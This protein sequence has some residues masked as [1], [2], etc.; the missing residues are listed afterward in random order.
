MIGGPLRLGFI[1]L[2]D[3][4]PLAVADASGLFEAE[5]L[6]VTLVREA[7]WAT[8]RDKVQARLLDGAHMLGPMPLASSLGAGGERSA[9]IAPMTLN[10]N[11][12]AISVSHALA[13]RMR[14][15]DPQAMAARPRTAQ[16]LRQVVEERRRMGAPPLT[17]AAVFP[18]SLHAYVLRHWLAEAGVDPDR[19]V[20]LVITPPPRMTAQLRSGE[21]DGFCV[22]APWNAVAEADGSGEILVRTRELWPG[23]TDK[24]LGVSAVFAEREP[25]ALLAVL[26]ALIKAAAWADAPENRPALARLLARPQYVGQPEAVLAKSLVDSPGALVFHAGGANL[27]SLDEA[28]WLLAQ[29]RRWGQIGPDVDT[30]ATAAAV[31]RPDLY[32]L[33]VAAA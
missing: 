24:V 11:G 15:L 28:A 19:D 8:I 2:A 32:R 21:I 9:M 33:A 14:G 22:G 29:M 1:P 13:E 7:S 26:R 30:G 6:G 17:F 4:A 23:K 5:G 27:P 16:A 25:Q 20:R 3:C 10:Q 12:G 31:Y 18:F